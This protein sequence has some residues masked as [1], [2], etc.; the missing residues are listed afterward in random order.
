MPNFYGGHGMIPMLRFEIVYSGL[1]LE[2]R[3]GCLHFPV[4]TFTI[5]KENSIKST[6][7][8]NMHCIIFDF[9]ASF[10]WLLH[11]T[12]PNEIRSDVKK[13]PT[14][15]RMLYCIIINGLC[16]TP[17]MMMQMSFFQLISF[18]AQGMQYTNLK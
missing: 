13:E 9:Q 11:A 15:G 14:L 17:V 18:D 3:V 7:S 6:Y 10:Q 12:L 2:V 1:Q 16:C 4:M 8:C 5:D